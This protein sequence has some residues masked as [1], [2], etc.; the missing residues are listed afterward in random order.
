MKL[1]QFKFDLP[2]NLIAQSPLKRR[3]DSRLMVIDRKT[4]EMRD[5]HFY[6]IM[7]FFND[8]DVFVVNN[9]KVFPARMYGRKEKTGAK[10]EVFLLRELNRPNRL[11]DVIVDPAR[12]IRVGNKLYFGDN[13]ELVAEVID[14]TTSRGRTIKFLWD[15]TEEAFRKMLDFLGETPLPKYIKRKPD[16]T[17]K[18]RYQTVYA[19]YE[20]A[21]AAPTAGLHFS[22]EL[23]KRCEIKGV[24]FAE[25]TLHTGLGTFRPIEVEDLSKHKM[26]AEYY[27]IDETACRIVNKAKTEGHRICSIGTTTMRGLET[28]FTAEK[29]L[30]PSEGW[31]NMF[32]HPPY[33]FN[34]AD[35][36][37]TNFHLPK[38]S[39]LIM[40]CSFAG[41][42]LVMEAYKKA[43]KDKYRFF[44]Y[45]DAMLIL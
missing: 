15:D 40:A 3:E 28:S 44:T 35:S 13:D 23:I 5:H 32:I 9:T 4:G 24:R 20:G 37:V 1:S 11:W 26:D 29:L 38:T 33:D 12:K 36:L 45:G 10:I 41:Y 6:E 18:E 31:T 42:D 25:V 14:N 30:K 39:L 17:D 22:R 7:D 16:E 8:K 19:K 27:R 43:I 34:I 2:L 21:V